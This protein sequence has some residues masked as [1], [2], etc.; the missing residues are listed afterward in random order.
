MRSL[1][2]R[3]ALLTGSIAALAVFIAGMAALPLIR[4]AAEQQVRSSLARQADLVR[5]IANNPSDF[6]ADHL[7]RGGS[8][9]RTLVG[10][11]GYLRTQGVQV[12]AVIPGTQVPK[13]LTPKDV[14]L[15]VQGNDVSEKHCHRD[16]CLFVEARPVGIGTGIVLTQSASVASSVSGAALGRI[17]VPLLAGFIV[18]GFVGLAVTRRLIKPLSHAAQAAHQLAAGQ[19]D[20]RL[21]PEGPVEIAQIAQALNKLAEEL[22]ASESRQREFLMSVSHEL[23]TP[24]TAIRG[25]AEGMSDGIVASDE[26]A[27]VGQIIESESVR[28]DRL[29]SDLLDLARTGAVDFPLELQDF[30][31]HSVMREAAAVWQVRAS[32]EGVNFELQ[33]PPE[34]VIVHSD[35]MRVRQIVDNLAEN[36]L[37]VT[38]KGAKIVFALDE[39]AVIH[40]RDGGPGLTVEDRHV[41]F[42]LGEL[43]WRY[44]G[45]RKVGTGFGLALVGRLSQRLNA[46]ASVTDAPEGGAAFHIDLGNV[47]LT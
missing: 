13:F 22:S 16:D 11:I 12:E 6:D 10:L 3:A 34:S 1:E 15:I 9:E 45:V 4:G 44:K 19:R 47:K 42:Q 38:P 32:R 41:A 24:L 21:E 7:G 36:A 14:Q 28:L 31:L 37:R 27:S 23:R 30:D 39:A 25:Y 5:D 20:I 35:A 33:L 17:V 2:T 46:T 40:V 18:A 26:M 8:P 29:V 43:F